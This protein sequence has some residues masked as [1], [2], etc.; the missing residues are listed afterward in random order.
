MLGKT[1]PVCTLLGLQALLALMCDFATCIDFAGPVTRR[2][3]G[4]LVSHGRPGSERVSFSPVL[5][6]SPS[7]VAEHLWVRPG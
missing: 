2:L 5:Q 6:F 7:F 4:A 1:L 3:V